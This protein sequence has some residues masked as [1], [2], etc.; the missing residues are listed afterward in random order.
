[1]KNAHLNNP[2]N[3]G[4]LQPRGYG[5]RDVDP[6]KRIMRLAYF[7]HAG[8]AS[9]EQEPITVAVAILVDPDREWKKV[10]ASRDQLLNLF[11]LEPDTEIH[12]HELFPYP[13]AQPFLKQHI[14][15]LATHQLPMFYGAVDRR[16]FRQDFPNLPPNE[17]DRDVKL[18]SFMYAVQMLDLW[19]QLY[20]PDEVAICIP[21][22]EQYRRQ[23]Q[24]QSF[25]QAAV[26]YYRKLEP[27]E[28][29]KLNN[30][31]E[32]PFFV[33]SAVSIG[34]QLA[35]NCVYMLKRYL[36][37]KPNMEDY[38]HLIQPLVIASYCYKDAEP[39]FR[40]KQC[41]PPVRLSN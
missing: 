14:G 23:K 39:Y 21:N 1:M 27:D 17:Q 6:C 40:D 37:G 11:H 4:S 32:A 9:I 12:A 7:D 38:M 5:I 8:L 20:H 31:V 30:I 35:D 19:L 29:C 36:S 41:P 25:I 16:L 13:E 28:E 3:S 10:E 2:H 26:A 34:V 33:D 22:E 18:L 24:K 15:I